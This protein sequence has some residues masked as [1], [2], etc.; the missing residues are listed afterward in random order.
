[1][2]MSSSECNK[3]GRLKLVEKDFWTRKKTEEGRTFTFIKNEKL[4]S[5]WN[6]NFL[7]LLTDRTGEDKAELI[8]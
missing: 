8:E 3:E 7:W 6:T 4:F 1:M 2:A 5:G